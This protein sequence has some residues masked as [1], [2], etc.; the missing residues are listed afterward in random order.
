MKDIDSDTG[1]ASSDRVESEDGSYASGSEKKPRKR[2]AKKA[3]RVSGRLLV[4]P[5]RRPKAVGLTDCHSGI[6]TCHPMSLHIVASADGIRDALLQWYSRVHMSRVMP[7]RKPYNPSHS[8]EERSQRAYEVS[9][10]SHFFDY[11]H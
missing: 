7:W 4:P 2:L 11:E 8:P 3:K 5:I 9:H 1:Y 6:E 10:F